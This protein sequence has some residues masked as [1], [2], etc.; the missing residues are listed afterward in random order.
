MADIVSK[1]QRSRMMSGI[2]SKD[3]K[4]EISIRKA[5]FSNGFRYRLH[6]QKLPGKPD[7]VF[8]KYKAVIFINGCFWHGHNCQLYTEPKSNTEFWRAKIERNRLN[9]IKNMISLQKKGWR[10]MNVWECSLRNRTISEIESVI[11][12]LTDWLRSSESFCEV[13]R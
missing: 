8:P 12:S 13:R 5:L 9:D 6:D 7:L 4:I 2:K 10:V 11:E 3:T 1:E